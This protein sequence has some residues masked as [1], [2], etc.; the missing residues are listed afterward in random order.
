[1]GRWI[2]LASNWLKTY[3]CDTPPLVH[4]HHEQEKQAES[5][6]LTADIARVFRRGVGA[7]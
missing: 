5:I 7:S 2:P 6:K 4:T 3:E 1:M